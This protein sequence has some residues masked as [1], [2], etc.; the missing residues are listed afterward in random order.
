[1]V[2]FLVE[3]TAVIGIIMAIAAEC[4]NRKFRT[5]RLVASFSGSLGVFRANGGRNC[6]YC[7]RVHRL[8]KH[9]QVHA[10]R[11]KIE[12]DKTRRSPGQVSS[13]W[14]GNCASIHMR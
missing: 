12:F 13:R 1:M 7:T 14:R 4:G 11:K 2:T 8:P 5:P 10:E 9:A 6:Q 3:V